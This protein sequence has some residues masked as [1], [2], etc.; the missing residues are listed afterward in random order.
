MQ[1]TLVDLSLLADVH[2]RAII[3]L[4]GSFPEREMTRD[5]NAP[6]TVTQRE[7]SCVIGGEAVKS[8]IKS[9]EKIPLQRC[10]VEYDQI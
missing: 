2:Q 4:L 7:K 3:A 9:F 8:R 6:N 5:K 1:A 10:H